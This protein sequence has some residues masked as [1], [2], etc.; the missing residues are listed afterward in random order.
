MEHKDYTAA[1]ICTYS[2]E[3]STAEGM[4]EKRHEDLL[5]CPHNRNTYSFPRIGKHDFDIS[6]TVL[7][8]VFTFSSKLLHLM[9]NPLTCKLANLSR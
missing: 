9:Q 3:M 4:L 1:W 8:A 5:H 7:L 2:V 6:L